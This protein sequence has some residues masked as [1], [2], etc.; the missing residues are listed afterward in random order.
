MMDYNVRD[1]KLEQQQARQARPVKWS[2]YT[3]NPDFYFY[4]EVIN[5]Y[6]M[7]M[8]E[9]ALTKVASIVNEFD[10]L[11]RDPE[12]AKLLMEARFIHRLK[13]GSKI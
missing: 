2:D 4:E 9:H 12:T 1:I 3:Y 5:M 13:H 7:T 6:N 11:M 8:P 10:S